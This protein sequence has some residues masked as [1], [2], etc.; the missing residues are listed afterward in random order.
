MR[1]CLIVSYF[2]NLKQ[3]GLGPLW[4]A[5]PQKIKPSDFHGRQVWVILNQAVTSIDE[6]WFHHQYEVHG[7]EADRGCGNG[8]GEPRK[9]GVTDI[10]YNK[11]T[12][13][14]ARV[15]R[16]R[17]PVGLSSISVLTN[18]T[19]GVTSC[20]LS[21][22][23]GIRGFL[24][25]WR[26]WQYVLSKRRLP[27]TLLL[28]VTKNK[29]WILNSTQLNSQI[30]HIH[31]RQA[32]L[33]QSKFYTLLLYQA[34]NPR[35]ISVCWIFRPL[36]DFYPETTG[37][38]YHNEH[39]GH[40]LWSI[41]CKRVESISARDLCETKYKQQI[42]EKNNDKKFV[43]CLEVQIVIYISKMFRKKNV[44]RATSLFLD[45]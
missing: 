2:E 29:T 32:L 37:N 34:E 11:Y 3:G 38:E 15:R 27:I 45:E 17:P 31:L 26:W 43:I 24:D 1:V 8:E 5:A 13:D 6:V 23:S 20:H 4:A 14:Y 44:A 10:L 30:S 16:N 21:Q 19:T 9:E 25:P 35:K 18:R 33:M 42:R 28:R 40:K 39:S 36:W 41:S 7:S 12:Y 22:V